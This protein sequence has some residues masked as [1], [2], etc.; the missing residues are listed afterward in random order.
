MYGSVEVMNTYLKIALICVSLICV[1]LTAAL[2]RSSSLLRDQR[3]MVVGIDSE[4]R[5][6]VLD[7]RVFEYQPRTEEIKYFLVRFVQ[8]HYSRMRATL[9]DDYARSLYFL[10]ADLADRGK[11]P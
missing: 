3:P 7:Y 2:L 4:G 5:P 8:Q 10:D 11:R 6:K 9:K 1:G